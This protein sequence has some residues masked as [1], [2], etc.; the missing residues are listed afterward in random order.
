MCKMPLTNIATLGYHFIMTM[1]AEIP[2]PA[3]FVCTVNV[4]DVVICIKSKV[5]VFLRM[6]HQYTP[7]FSLIMPILLFVSSDFVISI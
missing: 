7:S 6:L 3:Y 4:N 5:L 1:W 2:F